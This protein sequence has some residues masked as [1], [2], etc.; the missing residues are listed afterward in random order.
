MAFEAL[1]AVNGSGAY[2]NLA[3][4]DLISRHR[5]D[6]RDAAFATELLAGTCRM[7]GTYDRI[8]TS[9]A[10]RPLGSLQPAVVDVLRLGTHQLL[11]MRTPASAAVNTSV[12]L[13][14]GRIGRRATGVVNAILHRVAA[15]TLDGWLDRLA[16]PRAGE[17]ENLALRTGHPTWIVDA[18]ADVLP[19][20]ELES[21][22]RA[23]NDPPVPMLAVR[24]G[25]A[26]RSELL[27]AD[28]H[29]ARWSPW[30]VSRPG[31]PADLACVRDGRAGV[32]DEG[33]QLVVL[34]AVRALDRVGVR[35]TAQQ[36]EDES[37]GRPGTW[38]DLCAGPG[39]KSALLAGL[40]SQRGSW[41]LSNERHPHRARLVAQALRAYP[42]GSYQVVV[43]DGTAPA[44]REGSCRLV[45]ADVPCSGLGALRRR[46][47]ARWRRDP[48]DLAGLVSLQRRLLASACAA[49]APGGVLAFVTCSPHRSET[50]DVVHAVLETQ[51]GFELLDAPA[52]LPEVPDARA[53]TDPRFLQ[54]WPHRHGTDAM[55]AAILHR[56]RG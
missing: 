11:G 5:L 12:E 27:D 2:G 43:A 17:H 1:R 22:L 55:F 45:M 52:L 15:D 14:H 7:Q 36:P 21:A 56:R 41:L 9:A 29:P 37:E 3:L 39:G 16:D 31:N 4:P 34:A 47:E 18:F 25:L 38:L 42:R 26:E 35:P 51:P 53:L 44:W 40:A 23:D 30:G 33:S 20:G 10:G 49:V 19:P 48:Q 54:L 8:I 46:P 32:Q 24:P 50:A 6:A 13:A 28:A